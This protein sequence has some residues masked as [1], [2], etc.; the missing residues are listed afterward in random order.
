MSNNQN[1]QL[2]TILLIVF[3]GFIGASIAYPIFPPLFLH[4][5]ATNNLLAGPS[6]LIHNRSLLLGFTL[7]V[8]PL[9][10]FIGSPIIGALSDKYGR[11]YILVMSLAGTMLG[12]LLTALA[13]SSA[14]L[15]LLI[16]SRFFTGLMESNLAL[17]QSIITDLK[18]INKH[19]GFGGIT[20]AASTGY[21]AGPLLGGFLSDTTLVSWFTISFPFYMAALMSLITLVLAYLKIPETNKLRSNVGSMLRQFN[22]FFH[23]HEI[24]RSKLLTLL[25]II[26][27][28][29]TLSV[30]LFY[31][32]GPVFLTGEWMMNAA[33]IAIYNGALSLTIAIGG[34][35]PY[36]LQLVFSARE[37]IIA[38][39]ILFALF[40]LCIVMATSLYN[41]FFFFLIIGFFIPIT[42]TAL[43]VQLSDAAAEDRQGQIMGMQWGLRML[44]DA[45]I[46]IFGGMLIIYSVSLPL[47]LSAMTAILT[48]V[49]YFLLVRQANG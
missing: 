7:A 6:T 45:G 22:F 21:I 13:L 10:Q 27:L 41:L 24:R 44:G 14:Q 34:L 38:A 8:Y 46:C 29:F 11:R 49:I 48:A 3:V 33:Q 37:M 43:S 5:S 47:V 32:F 9:G 42:Q 19:K 35:L 1:T 28:I 25:L 36:R 23:L 40:L 12:Y 26:S 30:D 20:F 17:A 15:W 39:A 4:A 16:A 2:Y 31:E 18:D